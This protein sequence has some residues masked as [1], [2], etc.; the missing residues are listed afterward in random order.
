MVRPE[1]EK[2]AADARY[3]RA[4]E[5]KAAQARKLTELV[6]DEPEEEGVEGAEAL[7]EEPEEEGAEIPGLED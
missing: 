6:S 4:T 1:A 2:R 5:E 7:A 3:E